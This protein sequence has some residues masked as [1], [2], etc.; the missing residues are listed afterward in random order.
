MYKLQYFYIYFH[1][2][3]KE[4][5]R[6]SRGVEEPLWCCT[7]LRHRWSTR[8][9]CDTGNSYDRP[10]RCVD[11][12]LMN[13]RNQYTAVQQAKLLL[14]H[15]RSSSPN[16]DRL[17]FTFTYNMFWPTCFAD[18]ETLTLKA[19]IEFAYFW[20]DKS[21]S[22]RLNGKSQPVCYIGDSHSIPTIGL[23]SIHLERIT[24]TRRLHAKAI[25]RVLWMAGKHASRNKQRCQN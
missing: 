15:C 20:R 17:S 11:I 4:W 9:R 3:A 2:S 10:S 13:V 5:V 1:I 22:C 7:Y 21:Y 19:R 18:S 8:H 12:P 14:N 23:A 6:V 24:R 16:T 25:F